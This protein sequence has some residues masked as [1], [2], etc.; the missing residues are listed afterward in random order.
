MEHAGEVKRKYGDI[1]HCIELISMR[2]FYRESTAY[3]TKL[4]GLKFVFNYRK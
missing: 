4:F 1:K 2:I 3:F